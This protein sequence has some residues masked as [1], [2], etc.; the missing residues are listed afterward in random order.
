MRKID[1][2][3]HFW[4][5]SRGDYSWISPELKFIYKDFLP[6]DYTEVSKAADVEKTILIQAA[7]TIEETHY[8]LTL[9]NENDF[10]GGVVGWV[11]FESLQ[12]ISQLDKLSKSIYFKGVRPMLQDIVDPN[13][14]LNPEFKPVFRYLVNNDLTFDALVKTEHLDAIHIIAK[15][16]PRL[17]IVIDHIAKPDIASCAFAAWTRKLHKFQNLKNVYIKFSGLTT[18]AKPYQNKTN[19]FKYYL[20][21]VIEVFGHGKV[22]WGSDWPVVNLNSDFNLWINLCEELT[23]DFSTD[24]KSMFWAEC[25]H[26]FYNIEEK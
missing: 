8:L 1:S 11:D 4:K 22:M 5:L 23:K 15:E 18:E 25:S 26:E 7:D 2:H 21:H 6:K 9:A 3:Q 13:W 16:F 17:K 24:E 10:I 12:V 19:D 14:I 20:Q